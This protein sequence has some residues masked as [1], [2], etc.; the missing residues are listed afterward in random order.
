MNLIKEEKKYSEMFNLESE[1]FEGK[2]LVKLNR[3][4]VAFVEK[5]LSIDSRY[6]ERDDPK[7]PSYW[8]KNSAD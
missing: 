5:I 6:K 1:I 2:R 7:S 3:R 8:L 4:N